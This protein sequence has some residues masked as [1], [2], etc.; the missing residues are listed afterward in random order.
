[1]GTYV[2]EWMDLD[3]HGYGAV[4]ETPPSHRYTQTQH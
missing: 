1:M 3:D 4:L 2:P